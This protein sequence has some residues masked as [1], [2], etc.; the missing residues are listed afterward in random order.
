[1]GHLELDPFSSDC[2]VRS[3]PRLRRLPR[4]GE[5]S[6]VVRSDEKRA[7]EGERSYPPEDADPASVAARGEEIW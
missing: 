5:S 6:A 2:L 1:M 4:D 7:E 3:K